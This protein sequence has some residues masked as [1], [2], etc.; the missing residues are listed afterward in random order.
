MGG[1]AL[2]G[3]NE[4]CRPARIYLGWTG[5]FSGKYGLAANR[6]DFSTSRRLA[7]PGAVYAGS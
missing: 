3:R 7:N 5:I 2:V 1:G 6:D 4:Q